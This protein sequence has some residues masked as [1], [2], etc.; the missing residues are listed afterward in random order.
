G[1]GTR[2]GAALAGRTARV[3]VR[4]RL[5]RVDP[6]R[7]AESRARAVPAARY[8][9]GDRRGRPDRLRGDPGHRGTGGAAPLA[10]AA[11]TRAA[12]LGGHGWVVGIWSAVGVDTAFVPLPE[13]VLDPTGPAG[14]PRRGEPVRLGRHSVLAPGRTGPHRGIAV[15]ERAAVGVQSVAW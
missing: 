7:V 6:A 11:G 12:G 9:V 1:R 14:G 3:G 2:R 15:G 4:R 8:A 5:G 13:P 10:A